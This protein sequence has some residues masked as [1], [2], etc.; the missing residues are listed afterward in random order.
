L[1]FSMT[2]IDL[3]ASQ[4]GWAVLEA[5]L[6]VRQE[7]EPAAAQ[8]FSNVL[9]TFRDGLRGRRH[10]EAQQSFCLRAG[11]EKNS[12]MQTSPAG[13]QRGRF[14]SCMIC[15]EHD[16]NSRLATSFEHF[17]QSS[18]R[19]RRIFCVHM[20]DGAQVFETR[21]ARQWTAFVSKSPASCSNRFK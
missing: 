7:N 19:V 4:P 14:C 18:P 15:Q 12:V 10:R 16:A 5:L 3:V 1:D 8:Y 6:Q 2:I 20:E 21:S 9:V 11:E 17:L 13:F